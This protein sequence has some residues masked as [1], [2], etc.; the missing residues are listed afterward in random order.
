MFG[1]KKS[2]YEEQ[3][4]EVFTAIS[5]KR[6]V[7]ETSVGEVEEISTCMHSDVCQMME[8]TNDLVNHAMLNVEEESILI[9]SMD[10]FSKEL[11]QAADEYESLREALKEQLEAGTALVEDN[12][13]YTTPAKYL[14]E[15]PNTI[16]E[17]CESYGQHLDEMAE[18]GKKMGVLALNAAIEAGRMGTSGK[19]F[20]DAAEEIRQTASSYEKAALSMK[21]ELENSKEK[22]K[23]LEEVVYHLVSLLKETNM[24]PAR[25]M[26]KCQE[27]NQ[28]IQNSSTRDYSED[29][30]LL[31]DKVIGMRNLDEEIAK[32]GERNK[33]QL[34]DIGEDILNQK[35]ELAELESNISHLIDTAMEQLQ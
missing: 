28:L 17:V 2:K 1:N 4:K 32:I 3:V 18:H 29:M 19:Q 12:K 22:I 27:T 35:K 31:R 8:N 9:H 6:E 23:E 14:T 5:E 10:D 13:H 30:I 7:F 21:E 20:V 26:K 11:K 24:G 15:V 33:I 25:L 34:S 16:K